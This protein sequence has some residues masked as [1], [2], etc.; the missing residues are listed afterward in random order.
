MKEDTVSKYMAAIIEV[1]SAKV[2]K[3]E[4]GGLNIGGPG[5]I[6][7]IDDV[8]LAERKYIRGTELVWEHFWV[9]GMIEVEGGWIAFE[10]EEL[11]KRLIKREKSRF[12]ITPKKCL[13]KPRRR[14]A[15]RRS[16]RGMP[17]RC[18]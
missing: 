10:D 4:N 1:C 7:E 13:T 2:V 8:H 15:Q 17:R 9:F 5:K 3:M 16:P 18:P 11:Y 12:S 14:N 6:V